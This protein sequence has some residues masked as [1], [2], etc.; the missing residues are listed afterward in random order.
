MPCQHP[1]DS[2][3]NEFSKLYYDL[4]CLVGHDSTV[5]IHYSFS[6]H[7]SSKRRHHTFQIYELKMLNTLRRDS[8]VLLR[9]YSQSIQQSSNHKR[10]TICCISHYVKQMLT[11]LQCCFLFTIHHFFVY[12]LV[13]FH[14]PQNFHR[15]GVKSHKTSNKILLYYSNNT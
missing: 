6:G 11:S 14:S 15:Q 13:N 4:Q 9:Q 2:L 10:F 1:K 8:I 5:I 7:G 12:V 3:C